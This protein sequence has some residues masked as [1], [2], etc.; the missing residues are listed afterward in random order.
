MLLYILKFINQN[1]KQNTGGMLTARMQ[2][3]DT[4]FGLAYGSHVVVPERALCSTL[5]NTQ[6]IKICRKSVKLSINFNFND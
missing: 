1:K 2:E 4:G 5:T 3:T 6:K